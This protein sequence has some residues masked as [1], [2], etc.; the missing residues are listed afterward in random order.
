MTVDGT[1][2]LL[3]SDKLRYAMLYIY[4]NDVHK[5]ETVARRAIVN[6][7]SMDESSADHVTVAPSFHRTRYHW[8]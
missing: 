1:P 4:L 8:R 3:P 6:L 5:T 2:S 7:D